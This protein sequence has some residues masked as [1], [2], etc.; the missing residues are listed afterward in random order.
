MSETLRFS[1]SIKLP[2]K[3]ILALILTLI[4]PSTFYWAGYVY[5]SDVFTIYALNDA[6]SYLTQSATLVYAASS[7]L[8][9][10][11]AMLVKN[12]PAIK[13]LMIVL[14]TILQFLS[15][16]QFTLSVLNSMQNGFFDT[17]KIVFIYTEGYFPFQLLT[18]LALIP[19]IFLFRENYNWLRAEI[20]KF[21]S[22]LKLSGTNLKTLFAYSASTILAIVTIYGIYSNSKAIMDYSARFSRGFHPEIVL[23]FIA[24]FFDLIFTVSLISILLVYLFNHF[25]YI[26]K[27]I[28]D[29]NS[30]LRDF[31]L[32]N[33]VTRQI[34]GYLYWF[35]YVIV[36]GFFAIIGPFQTFVEFE[37]TRRYLESG[38][39]P[40]LI[41]VL[42]GIPLLTVFIAYFVI[43]ILRLIF[44][45]LIALIHIAQNTVSL[46][47]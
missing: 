17:L 11:T 38:F 46:R 43:L 18:T 10:L 8:A 28:R 13:S 9:T 3:A 15:L 6:V 29:L 45:L 25:D 20:S 4:V 47:R 32:S 37:Q 34:S 35:Y 2:E 12:R 40:Q 19:L 33:Y 26:N 7:Y 5:S 31:K 42:V 36:V 30:V 21:V 24:Y 41:L 1:V 16:T 44:E 14:A 27:E 23:A 39:Q 22:N